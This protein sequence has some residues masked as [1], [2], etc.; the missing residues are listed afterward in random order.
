M[1]QAAKVRQGVTHSLVT[2]EGMLHAAG[3]GAEAR[4]GGCT[5]L[6]SVEG[7][8]RDVAAG[9]GRA[10]ARLCIGL[11]PTASHVWSPCRPSAALSPVLLQGGYMNRGYLQ[12]HPNGTRCAC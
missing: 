5:P 7:G 9:Q 6:G 3:R 1:L 12:A 8:G 4:L 10:L 11:P 2:P